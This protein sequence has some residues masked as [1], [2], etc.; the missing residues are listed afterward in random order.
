MVFL[1][2]NYT[3]LKA[4]YKIKGTFPFL[5][6]VVCAYLDVGVQVCRL[7]D[8]HSSNSAV[9]YREELSLKA[10]HVKIQ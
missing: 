5:A 3:K 2:R 4:T 8:W 9:F 1:A 10:V 6:L 7:I